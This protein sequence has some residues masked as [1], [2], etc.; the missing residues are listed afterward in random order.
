MEVSWQVTGNR[1]DKHANGM[2]AVVE[3]QKVSKDLS[4]S[5][6][7]NRKNSKSHD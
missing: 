2:P 7:L 1:K 6:S 3:V 4:S 5:S